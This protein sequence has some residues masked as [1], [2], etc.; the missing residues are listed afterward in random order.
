[1]KII[2]KIILVLFSIVILIVSIVMVLLLSGIINFTTITSLYSKVVADGLVTN[3]TLGVS[4]VCALLAIKA[5]FFGG[6]L[7][8]KSGLTGEGILLENES[9]KLLISKDT[10]ENL[11][12]G[13]AKGFE[14]TQNAV[15]KVIV[16][17]DNTLRVF[18]TLMVLPNTVINELSVNLQKSIKEVVK[19]VTDLDIK[20]IDIKIKD[21]T[22]SEENKEG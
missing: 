22:T 3:I 16:D 7:A 10:I 18:V 21:I 2:D 14:N 12:S 19:N 4:V 11:V 1:M 17:S 6:S 5:I 20:S 15:S 13:V 8:P 9:G